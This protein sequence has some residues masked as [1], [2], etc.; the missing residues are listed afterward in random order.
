LHAITRQIPIAI[1]LG[2]KKEVE[3]SANICFSGNLITT[4]LTAILIWILYLSGISFKG[5]FDI[6]IMIMVSFIL[7]FQRY[8]SFLHS[9]IK[10]LGDFD[11]IARRNLYLNNFI[12]AFNLIFLA[13]WKLYGLVFGILFASVAG[14]LFYLKGIRGARFSFQLPLRKTIE[15]LKIGLIL[16][17]N[18]TSDLFFWTAD[19]TIIAIMMPMSAVGLYGFALGSVSAV[20]GFIAMINMVV[21]RKILIESTTN[22]ASG[23]YSSYRK[24]PEYYIPLLLTLTSLLLGIIYLGYSFIVRVFL[25]QYAESI[26]CIIILSLGYLC[27]VTRYFTF[28]FLN[29]TDQLK[30]QIIY[31]LFATV[32]NYGLDYL[33]IKLGYGIVGVA[34]GCSISFAVV[35]GVMLLHVYQNIYSQLI[36]GIIHSC[37]ITICSVSMCSLMWLFSHEQIVSVDSDV[38]LEKL[39][40]YGLDTGIKLFVYLV[41]CIG[42]FSLVFRSERL[43][44]NIRTYMEYAEEILKKMGF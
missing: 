26:P 38:L 11:L 21:Y 36:Q 31:T 19:L 4:I 43:L 44:P 12:P 25:H 2:N 32:L 39:F 9:Y 37:K 23:D 5:V 18:K 33:F 7:F 29:A 17:T 28:S 24:Y 10:G 16:F 30:Y 14:S 13:V 22:G 27:F 6:T 35:S 15:L 41:V 8:D 34:M 40:F 1:G 20:I 3:E 42:L